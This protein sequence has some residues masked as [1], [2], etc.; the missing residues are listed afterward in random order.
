MKQGH[1]N[2][3]WSQRL[4][5]ELAAG[6]LEC[7]W[8]CPGARNLPLLDAFKSSTQIDDVECL[9]EAA[10]AFQALGW[11]RGRRAAG[12]VESLAG[13]VCTSGSALLHA[14][15]ALAEAEAAGLPLMLIS[16]DRPPEDQ[17][18]GANQTMPADWV[19]PAML[20]G[21]REMP[22]PDEA[23]LSQASSMI[24]QL[25]NTALTEA[26]PVH[27]NQ[28]FREP[29]LEDED[30][31]KKPADLPQAS[32]RGSTRPL[33]LAPHL[34]ELNG[35]GLLYAC[36]LHHQADRQAALEWARLTGWPLLADAGSGL[37]ACGDPLVLRHGELLGSF[38][39]VD[40]VIQFGSMPVS[41]R[42]PARFREITRLIIDPHP[43]LRD[44]AFSGAPRLRARLRDTLDLAADLANLVGPGAVDLLQLDKSCEKQIEAAC[45]D[46]PWSEA[47]ITRSLLRQL[48]ADCGLM[49][50]NSLSVRLIDQYAP[51]DSQP[52]KLVTQRGLAGI[53]GNVA[54]A[55]GMC[56]ALDGP[57]ALLLGDL[58]LA[59]DL[60]SL[61]F[62]DDW[63]L[64]IVVLDNQGG[65][66]FELHA[67]SRGRDWA[68]F[69]RQLDFARIAAANGIESHR[70]TEPEEL[71]Q[72]LLDWKQQP[73]PCLLHVKLPAGSHKNWLT[74]LKDVR[75]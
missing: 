6:G 53:D 15:P 68:R 38:E 45:Q 56:R 44:P 69:T 39:Q 60:G 71:L 50:G 34:P 25:C 21:R 58:S 10:A 59:H 2:Q 54:G 20:R 52:L 73:A 67:A 9:N 75:S 16:A 51:A 24:R 49:L 8:L 47:A 29:L 11:L 3:R 64:L 27:L 30:I 22:L 33:D 48:P 7:V 18:C 31:A 19:A 4:V 13:V 43:G 23:L 61:Q 42:L 26:G 62:V 63:P 32:V 37:A 14:G 55:I 35:C 70:L 72:R 5:S 57:A 17:A 1:L 46:Y 12:D 36:S 41:R 66:I 28:P 65:G 40:H 74:R